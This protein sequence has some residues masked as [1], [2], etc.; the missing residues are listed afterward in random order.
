VKRTGTRYNWFKL[1]THKPTRFARQ[2]LC[3]LR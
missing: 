1:M 3:R 2:I